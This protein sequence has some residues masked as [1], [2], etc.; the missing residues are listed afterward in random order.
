[1]VIETITSDFIGTQF[2]EPHYRNYLSKFMDE[3]ALTGFNLSGKKY[4]ILK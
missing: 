3:N 2:S 1:M 4:I